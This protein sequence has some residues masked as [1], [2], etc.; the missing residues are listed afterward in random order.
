M[1]ALTRGGTKAFFA[2]L[3]CV[4]DFPPGESLKPD[5]PCIKKYKNTSW[6]HN[7]VDVVE[8]K[9]YIY[10]P[11]RKTSSRYVTQVSYRC[12]PDNAKS[13]KIRSN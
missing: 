13:R 6:V 4:G 3:L 10:V 11:M 5:A 12:L 2:L 9:D 7:N 1:F 8:G